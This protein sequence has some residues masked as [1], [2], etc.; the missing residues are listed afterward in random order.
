MSRRRWSVAVALALA[1]LTASAP[2]V[3]PA[4]GSAK[5]T[6]TPQPSPIKHVIFIYNENHSF[7]NIFGKYC[8]AKPVGHCEG[9]T[10]PVTFSNGGTYN[11]QPAADIVPDSCHEV[12]CLQQVL[13]G[14]KMD[15]WDKLNTC[16]PTQLACLQQFSPKQVG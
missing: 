8:A 15:G 13:D 6:T 2:F 1:A 16:G 5:A 11:M 7:D 3:I 12:A 14:S 10:G 4:L 9:K